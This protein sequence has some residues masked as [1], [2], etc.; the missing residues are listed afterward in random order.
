M[1]HIGFAG[2]MGQSAGTL[3]AK[4]YILNRLSWSNGSFWGQVFGS[5][6]VRLGSR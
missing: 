3:N 5:M 4:R 1:Y 2:F 6:L